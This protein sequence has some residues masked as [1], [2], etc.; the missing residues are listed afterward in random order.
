MKRRT[1][2]LGNGKLRTRKTGVRTPKKKAIT[3]IPWVFYANQVVYLKRILWELYVFLA[4]KSGELV[5]REQPIILI[6]PK[7]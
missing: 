2:K 4:I 1:R 3:M 7:N 5:L 6:F